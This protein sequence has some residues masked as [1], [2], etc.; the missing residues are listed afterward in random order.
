[1]KRRSLMVAVAAIPLL[2]ALCAHAAAPR[3]H[4]YK[5][6]SC[7]CCT[8]WVEHLKAAGFS[9]DVTQTDDTAAVRKRLGMPERLAGCHTGVVDGYAIEGHVP[10][11]DIR[12]LLARKPQAV[13]LAVPGM[14][15]GSPGMEYGDKVE[16]YK[17]LLVDR[18]GRDTVF[19]SYPQ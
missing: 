7:G 2:P 19:A 14:P 4:V 13:G 6:P 8:A 17:V 5:N 9:V 10:A 15:V 18:K 3:V 11:A 16:P 12:R 1:M